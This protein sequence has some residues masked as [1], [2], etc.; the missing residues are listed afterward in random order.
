MFAKSL[1]FTIIV[2]HSFYIQLYLPLALVAG[3]ATITKGTTIAHAC[4][5]KGFTNRS[6]PI[7]I[8]FFD[9]TIF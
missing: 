7:I 9:I 2:I 4:V 1:Q 6:R 8:A 5:A 3:F